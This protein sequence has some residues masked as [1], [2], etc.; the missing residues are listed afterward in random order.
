MSNRKNTSAET[1]EAPEKPRRMVTVSGITYPVVRTYYDVSQD[2]VIDVYE[3]TKTVPVRGGGFK[4]VT[5]FKHTCCTDPE[6]QKKYRRGDKKV[7]EL[8]VEIDG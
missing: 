3:K 7:I 5:L 6:L 1:T 4:D 8:E 2:L